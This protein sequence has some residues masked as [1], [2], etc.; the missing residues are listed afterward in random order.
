MSS[1]PLFDAASSSCI[2][3]ERC[4]LK[5]THDSHSLQASFSLVRLKQFIVFAKI[6][7]H[8]VLPTPLGPLKRYACASFL[9]VIAFFRVVVS[10]SCPTTEDRKSTRLNSSHVR[11]SYAVI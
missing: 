11:T 8:V 5:A 10:A 9:P 7:A 4:S 2:L 1:T 6:L 3:Y